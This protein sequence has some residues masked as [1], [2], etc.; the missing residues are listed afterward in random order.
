MT[1]TFLQIDESDPDGTPVVVA[2]TVGAN[3]GVGETIAVRGGQLI[4][5][6]ARIALADD[7]AWGPRRFEL[8]RSRSP[9][10]RA[11]SVRAPSTGAILRVSWRTLRTR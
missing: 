10:L 9:L 3:A 1:E 5:I 6:D 11:P 8:L 7:P 2:T 4:P